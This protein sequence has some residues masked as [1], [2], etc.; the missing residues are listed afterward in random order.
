MQT[1]SS[2]L[3]SGTSG[4][5]SLLAGL[6]QRQ[7]RFAMGMAIIAGLALAVAALATWNVSD[8]SFSNANGATPDNALGFSGAVF[9]DLVMQ[10]FGLAG[11]IGLLPALAWALR[12]MRNRPIDRMSKRAPAWFAGAWLTAA[13]FGLMPHSQDWPLPNGLGGVLGDMALKIP[14]TVIGG[15][16][17]GIVAVILG[18]LLLPPALWLL[19]YGAALI[20]CP[21]SVENGVAELSDDPAEDEEALTRGELLLGALGHGW[22]TLRGRLRRL[23]GFGPSQSRRAM[24]DEPLD[25]N[26][27]FDAPDVYAEPGRS[28]ARVEPGFAS[29]T[30]TARSRAFDDEPPFDLDDGPLPEGLLSSCPA[31]SP[32]AAGGWSAECRAAGCLMAFALG[33]FQGVAG[34]VINVEDFGVPSMGARWS[35]FMS[36][37]PA[38]GV[39][40]AR[41]IGLADDIARSM[42]AISARVAVV[43]GRNAIG[44]ELPNNTARRSICREIDRPRRFRQA[45]R[46]ICRWPWARPLAA[47]R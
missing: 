10:F 42:S 24:P 26:D 1:G 25:L 45:P 32:G 23:A 31:T 14:A 35:R 21:P 41:V 11:V 17:S 36:F 18:L 27:D 19:G 6:F 38:P 12:L 15:F 39:K 33:R 4:R 5:S 13:F 30:G 29:A 16:P 2:T 34:E 46:A 47:S 9:A 3:S 28:G 40:S 43:P 7:L 20:G 44:I 37:E 22:Y 8:P